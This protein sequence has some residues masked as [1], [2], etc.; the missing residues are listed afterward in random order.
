MQQLSPLLPIFDLSASCS[1]RVGVKHCNSGR[2]ARLRLA[3]PVHCTQLSKFELET[4]SHRFPRDHSQISALEDPVNSTPKRFIA[5][6]ARTGRGRRGKHRASPGLGEAGFQVPRL[7]FK[8]ISR[9]F[10]LVRVKP[11]TLPGRARADALDAEFMI[12]KRNTLLFLVALGR[13]FPGHCVKE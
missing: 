6:G 1:A 2:A 12:A 8:R 7:D 3:K 10:F 11:L 5:R 4:R 9:D 13:L